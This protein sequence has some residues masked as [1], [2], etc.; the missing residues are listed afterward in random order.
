MKTNPVDAHAEFSEAGPL[1]A[2]LESR[3]A[4]S[5]RLS[6]YRLRLLIQFI[7]ETLASPGLHLLGEVFNVFGIGASFKD[8]TGVEVDEFVVRRRIE[9]TLILLK[10][11]RCEAKEVPFRAGFSDSL[12]FEE[13]FIL[14]TGVEPAIYRRELLGQRCLF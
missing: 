7:D 2:T 9:R 14:L 11:M 6:S 3:P 13:Y 10:E 5:S 4:E 12:E 8:A 1:L